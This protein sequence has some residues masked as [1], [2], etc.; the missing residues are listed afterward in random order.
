MRITLNL[1]G[2]DMEVDVQSGELLLET[3]RRLGCW[4]VKHGCETGECGSCSVL[5][6]DRLVPSCLLPAAHADG[7]RL[8]T[9]EA[10]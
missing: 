3:L 4:S 10:A 1:N 6:D 7:H 8:L 5:L 9:V 2:R